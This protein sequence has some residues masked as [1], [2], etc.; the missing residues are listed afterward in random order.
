MNEATTAYQVRNSSFNI[1]GPQ[2]TEEHL[3]NNINSEEY[4]EKAK[5]LLPFGALF[6]A[7]IIV[8][9]KGVYV[10]TSEG[11]KILDF[12]SGQMSCLIGHGNLEVAEV[13]SRFAYNLDHLFSGML[14]PPVIDLAYMLKSVLPEG[15]DRSQFLSTGGEA[16]EAAIKLAKVYTGKHEIVGL[17]SSWH[18]MTGAASASTYHS[19]RKNYGPITPGNLVLPTPN[20]YRSIFRKKDGSYDWET[21]LDYG[22]SMVDT[23]SIGSLA[24]VIIEPILSSGG[25][26]V[27]PEGYLEA[28]KRYCEERDMLLIIDE[29][30][31][32]LGRCGSMFAFQDTKIV[33]D[34]LTLSKTLGNGIPLASC[35]TSNEIAETTKKKG[36]LFYT[37]HTNDPL[38]CAVGSKVIDVVLRD[39]L[40]ERSYKLGIKFRDGLKGIMSKYKCVGDVRGKGLM[41][42]LEIVKDHDTKEPH[43]ELAS[44]LANKM[45]ELGVSANLVAVKSFG[46]T[47]RIAPP[48]TISEEELDEG[49]RIMETAFLLVDGT[50]PVS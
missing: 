17:S 2:M 49:V 39:N 7:M 28:M 31:T 9:A 41:V 44:A 1:V 47:F 5:T 3:Y 15:L 14:S 33:P 42:G 19:G 11:K 45:I 12:T 10:Y 23:S 35:I 32:A 16:N 21:E 4:M 13:I 25:M 29:A 27:L 24:A 43:P 37:T 50:L 26:L 46:N 38:P 40:P 20:A 6:A 48:L 34:I 36:F 18:G 30:Q 8:G 22:W